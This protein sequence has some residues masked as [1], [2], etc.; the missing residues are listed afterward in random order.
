MES[1]GMPK[2]E[3]PPNLR[4]SRE[5]MKREGPLAR[6][7]RH[8]E[9]GRFQPDINRGLRATVGFMAPMLATVYWELPIEV[10]VAAIAGQNI[11][12]VDVRGSY[13]LR[14]SL[15]VAMTAILAGACWL[16]GI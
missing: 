16:G 14:A 13:P 11:A 7:R 8:L 1:G 6:I 12:M 9:Q 5:A 2:L 15:L 4:S 3:S 10:S